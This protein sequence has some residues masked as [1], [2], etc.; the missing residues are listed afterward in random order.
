MI[1]KIEVF[2]LTMD[3]QRLCTEKNVCSEQERSGRA[4]RGRKEKQLR[5]NR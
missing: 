3:E 5:G 2:E 1:E 4:G